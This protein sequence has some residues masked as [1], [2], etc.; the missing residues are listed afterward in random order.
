MKTI[1]LLTLTRLKSGIATEASA[2]TS[3]YGFY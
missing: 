1:N 3:P 2:V